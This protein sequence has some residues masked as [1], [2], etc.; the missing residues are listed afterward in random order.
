MGVGGTL[1]SAVQDIQNLIKAAF[2]ASPRVFFPVSASSDPGQ[3]TTAWGRQL[4][5]YLSA[6][7]SLIGNGEKSHYK[8]VELITRPPPHPQQDHVCLGPHC[9]CSFLAGPAQSKDPQYVEVPISGPAG[10]RPGGA[11]RAARVHLPAWVVNS[12]RDAVTPHGGSCGVLGPVG[13][14]LAAVTP[15]PLRFH[16]RS[17]TAPKAT[18]VDQTGKFRDRIRI[19]HCEGHTSCCSCHCCGGHTS[20][21]LLPESVPLVFADL[22][23]GLQAASHFLNA[24]GAEED[25][26]FGQEGTNAGMARA[27]RAMCACFD[28]GRLVG[29]GLVPTANDLAEFEVL[30]R[31]LDPYLQYTEWPSK[32][33]FPEVLHGWPPPEELKVQYVVLMHRLR[34]AA[35]MPRFR[36]SWW[37]VTGYYVEPLRTFPSVLRLVRCIYGSRAHALEARREWLCRIAAIVSS[38]LGRGIADQVAGTAPDALAAPSAFF[39]STRLL[40]RCGFPWRGRKRPHQ[41]RRSAKEAW[42]FQL[43]P[44]NVGVLLLP[45]RVGHL[46]HVTRTVREL[47]WSAVSASIDGDPFFSTGK[48]LESPVAVHNA[49]GAQGPHSAWHAVRIHHQCRPMGSPEAC[50]ERAG[51]LMQHRWAKNRHPDPGT[52]MDGVLLQ[53]AQVACIGGERDEALCRDVAQILTAS[54][55]RPFVAFKGSKRRRKREGIAHSRSLHIF[56]DDMQRALEASGRLPHGPGGPGADDS[57]SSESSSDSGEGGVQL[58]RR[59]KVRPCGHRGSTSTRNGLALAG[60]LGIRTAGD[61]EDLRQ[62]RRAKAQPAMQLSVRCEQALKRSVSNSHVAGQPVYK[63]DPRKTR[64]GRA[65]SAVHSDLATWLATADGRRYQEERAALATS[66]CPG[67]NRRPGGDRRLGGGAAKSASSKG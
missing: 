20:R 63:E 43:G 61:V 56:R 25:A 23:D 55:R 22:D 10:S 31:L 57:E 8:R 37:S 17:R 47:N 49:R 28:W 39:I 27:L 36:H 54:G 45:G 30:A 6:L 53:D 65:D 33:N 42:T 4:P 51:S 48:V 41:L 35:S 64:R 59:K 21:C 14:A 26:V 1:G 38:M 60:T 67:G 3:C 15:A 7:C 16:W 66:T 9:Q 19:H 58:G 2:Y 18:G 12:P 11:A 40:A 5:S 13:H 29:D 24:L 44:G 50:C 32:E 34:A 62:L 52:L 46:V